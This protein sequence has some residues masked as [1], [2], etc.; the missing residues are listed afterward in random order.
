[1]IT[2]KRPAASQRA[3]SCSRGSAAWMAPPAKSVPLRAQASTIASASA[4]GPPN[5]FSHCTART[6]PAAAHASTLSLK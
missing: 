2:P 3:H 4:S 5:G 1:M 6:H